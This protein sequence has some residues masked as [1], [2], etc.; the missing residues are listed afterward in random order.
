MSQ[1]LLQ[2]LSNRDLDWL[3]TTGRRRRVEA[4]RLLVRAGQEI[5]AFYILIEGILTISVPQNEDNILDRAFAALEDQATWERDIIEL[6][7][8]DIAG[9]EFLIKTG[10]VA[11][12]VRT[13]V[14]SEVLIIPPEKLKL[15]LQQD[16]GFAARFYRGV[17]LLLTERLLKL[18]NKLRTTRSNFASTQSRDVLFAFGRLHDSDLDWLIS[19]GNCQQF[20]AGSTLLEEGKPAETLYLLLNGLAKVAIAQTEINPLDLAFAALGTIKT[21]GLGKEIAI[22]HPGEFIGEMPFG[23]MRLASSTVYAVEDSQVLAIPIHSLKL[24]LQQDLGWASRFEAVVATL[25]GSRF[26]DT[27]TRLGYGRGFYSSGQTLSQNCSYE[28]E[29]DFESLDNLNLA[30]SRFRWLLDRLQVLTQNNL[31]EI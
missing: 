13:K 5:S 1:T 31:V 4:D 14:P 30:G 21:D 23:E 26:Q 22:I 24:K 2:E 20:L 3:M 6:K 17:A 11:N 25:A 29:L 9:E 10:M 28:D 18:T 16:I 27:I 12:N 8:G 7:S 19:H 15:K